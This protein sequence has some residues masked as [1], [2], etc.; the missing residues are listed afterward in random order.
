MLDA[1]IRAAEGSHRTLT[2]I[3]G[4]AGQ[5]LEAEALWKRIGLTPMIGQN[6]VPDQIFTLEDAQGLNAFAQERGVGR[7]SMWS[8]NRD[9]GCSSL[10]QVQ[11]PSVATHSCS[12]LEGHP[13]MF[14]EALGRGFADTDSSAGP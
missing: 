12:G 9:L 11:L 7:M 14:A 1:S 3:Y 8:L 10:D 5:P 4:R 6:D 13:G 2:G